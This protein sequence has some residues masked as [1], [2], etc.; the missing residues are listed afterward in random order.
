MLAQIKDMSIGMEGDIRVSLSLPR[1]YIDNLTKLRDEEKLDVVIK[2]YKERRSMSSNAYLWVLIGKIAEAITPPLNKDEVYIEMLKR[3]GQGGIVSVQKDK[4]DDVLRAFDYYV[5]KGE[6][7]VNG[8]EFIHMMVYVGS[9]KYNSKE[10]YLLI[11]GVVSE[12]QE[13]GVETLTPNELMQL[14]GIR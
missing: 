3:Y 6:G 8:K 11:Q 12:A 2:K 10:M 7:R 4:A 5:P 13:L 1:Q 14:E 9:S